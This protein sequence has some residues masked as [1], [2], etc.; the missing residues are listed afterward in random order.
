MLIDIDDSLSGKERRRILRIAPVKYALDKFDGHR[1]KVSKF[2]GICVR[3]LRNIINENK[4]ET[5]EE[6]VYRRIRNKYKARK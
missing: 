5:L 4:E 2:L 1:G 3:S 6:Q